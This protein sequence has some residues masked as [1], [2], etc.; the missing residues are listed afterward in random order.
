MNDNK[1]LHLY[2]GVR[3]IQIL[4]I[5]FCISLYVLPITIYYVF[6]FFFFFFSSFGCFIRK[7]K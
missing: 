6:N 1:G 3:G 2:R 4:Y 5:T 7:V